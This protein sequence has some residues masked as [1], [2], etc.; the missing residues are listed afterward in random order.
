MSDM[1][2]LIKNFLII[3]ISS[4]VILVLCELFLRAKHYIIPNYDIEMWKYSKLLKSKSKNPTIGHIHVPN[5]KAILQKKEIRINNIGQRGKDL[6]IN[7]LDI[8]DRKIMF[9]GSS[10]LLG[11]GVEEEK[12]FTSIIK[13]KA[14][15]DNR[16]WLV[17]NGGIGNYNTTRY[18]ENYL[19]NWSEIEIDDLI[20]A[21]FINDT[22]ILKQQNPN[23]FEKH[24]HIGVLIWKFINSQKNLLKNENVI[25]YYK[26]IYE[27]DF[28]GFNIAKNELK[29]LNFHCVIKNIKCRIILIPHVLNIKPYQ[30]KF[31][32]EKI[33]NFSK[34]NDI[35]YYDLLHD[36]Q[37]Y[38]NT[39]LM[40]DY[41]DRHI[42]AFSHNVIGER[43]YEILN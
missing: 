17:M 5:K 43:L 3:L 23:F 37:K 12:I 35:E 36:L 20:V 1:I 26:N 14:E 8:Y 9:I 30:F 29:K 22:E 40:N 4:I 2:N 15:I 33:I 10:M 31:I 27:D 11:W 21:Y 24:T 32:N 42:N 28:E 25:D 38:E 39:K 7:K 34:N 18:V 6:D 19:E 41:N 16:K 13:K